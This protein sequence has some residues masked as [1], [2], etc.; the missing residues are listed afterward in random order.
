MGWTTTSDTTS[1]STSYA[2]GFMSGGTIYIRFDQQQRQR[3]VPP[4]RP[5]AQ[6]PQLHPCAVLGIPCRSPLTQV[7]SAYRR[8]AKANHPDL[9]PTDA[10]EREKRTRRMAELNTAYAMLTP[11]ERSA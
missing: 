8:L 6:K 1:N 2:G 10:S 4:Q 3:Q 5:E 9:G 7:R 11:K